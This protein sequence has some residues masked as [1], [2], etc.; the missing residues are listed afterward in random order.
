[1]SSLTR[2]I[3]GGAAKQS[4][5]NSSRKPPLRVGKVEEVKG[6]MQFDPCRPVVEAKNKPYVRDAPPAHPHRLT[7]HS[8]ISNHALQ[9]TPASKDH[10]RDHSEAVTKHRENLVKVNAVKRI[11]RNS[12]ALFSFTGR[13]KKREKEQDM[14][15][16]DEPRLF[17][18]SGSTHF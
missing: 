6:E 10:G 5:R 8:K 14:K 13:S 15:E 18:K 16:E 4:P 2:K 1:M 12:I 9:G 11:S 3:F 17:V 7:I